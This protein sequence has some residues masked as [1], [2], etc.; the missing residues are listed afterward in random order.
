MERPPAPP[1]TSRAQQVEIPTLLRPH[2]T[3]TPLLLLPCAKHQSSDVL[4]KTETSVP[5]PRGNRDV[6]RAEAVLSS[7]VWQSRGGSFVKSGLCFPHVGTE[8]TRIKTIAQHKCHLPL[9]SLT[10]SLFSCMRFG[11]SLSKKASSEK[12]LQTA[13]T[14]FWDG[15]ESNLGQ[16]HRGLYLKCK[17]V[18]FPCGI[19]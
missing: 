18:P 10:S 1:G 16:S 4:G 7:L 5:K 12:V 2:R 15:N 13:E 19:T 9:C 14:F 11:C 3:A 6:S 8:I 17:S